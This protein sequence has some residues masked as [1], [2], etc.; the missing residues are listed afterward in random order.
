[1]TFIVEDSGVQRGVTIVNKVSTSNGTTQNL[2]VCNGVPGDGPGGDICNVVASKVT[3][4]P[5]SNTGIRN[6]N[7]GDG[8]DSNNSSSNGSGDDDTDNGQDNDADNGDNS[9]DDSSDGSDSDSDDAETAFL[10]SSGFR[11][12]RRSVDISAPSVS[13]GSLSLTRAF[14]PSSS[15]PVVTSVLL[16]QDVFAQDNAVNMSS[17]CVRAMQWPNE[18]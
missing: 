9:D 1:M 11:A 2:T 14:D 18:M 8:N 13:K 7:S 5:V 15:T 16:S 6:V 10:N 3:G 12:V 4:S 17:N